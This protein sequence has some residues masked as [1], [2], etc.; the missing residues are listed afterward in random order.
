MLKIRKISPEES[1]ESLELLRI[2]FPS[3][4]HVIC[5]DV[6]GKAGEPRKKDSSGVFVQQENSAL[7]PISTVNTDGTT[8]TISGLVT[9][10]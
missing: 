6:E 2:S 5:L 8:W 1:M 9:N 10:Y 7:F 4:L 3:F